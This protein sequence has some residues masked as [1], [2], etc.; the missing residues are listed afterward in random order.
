MWPSI[1][2]SKPPAAVAADSPGPA[3]PQPA[4]AAALLALL[5]L[6]GFAA[7]ALLSA[8]LMVNAAREPWA[9][10]V[11][12]GPLVVAMAGAAWQRRQWW[13]L[14]ACGAG[15]ALLAWVV[16]RGGVA[17]ANRMYVLQHGG[18]HLALAWAFG[19]TLRP[20]ST[21]LITA[22]A[23]TVHEDFTPEM[24]AYTRWLTG[25]WAAY[26]LSMLVVS[27]LVYTFAP[28]PWW[29]VYGNLLTP[30]SAGAFFVIEHRLRYRRHPD[31]ERVS[32]RL[33][34]SAYRRLS[35]RPDA[36]RP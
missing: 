8:W 32:I 3:G 20:G 18:I 31:F 9:V 26:F 12:F 21:P 35:A 2:P 6:G 16:A 25:L 10:A 24:Q 33:A 13:V 28:W 22:L 27:A 15:V 7:Y 11:L 30:L 34:I 4:A 23:A 19:S 14:G 17:D 36:P 1:A 5:T 29:S